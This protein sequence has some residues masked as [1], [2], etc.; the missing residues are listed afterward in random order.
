MRA[1][2]NKR[3]TVR[4]GAIVPFVALSLVAIVG[5]IAVVIDG[6]LLRDNRR[7]VQA[8]ADAAALAA[9]YDLYN[10]FQRFAGVDTGGTASRS[11]FATANANGYTNDTT[12][13]VVTVNIPPASGN[14]V[15]KPGYAE[16]IIEYKQK[17]GF[18]GMWGSGR[19][20]VK[21]RAVARGNWLSFPNGIIVLDPTD[22][23]SLNA[24]GGSQVTVTNASVI[25]NSTD[26]AGA[27]ATGGGTL[28][29]SDLY[30]GGSPGWSVS[31]GSTITGNI[32]SNSLPTPDPL[33]YLPY[34]DPSTM[35]VQDS[36]GAHISGNGNNTKTLFPGVYH[37]GISITGSP[38]VI[39]MPGIYYLDGGGFSYTG[40]GSLTGTGIMFFNAPHSN[41]DVINISGGGAVNISPPTTGIYAGITIFQERSSTNIV[42]LTGNGQMQ[43]SGTFYVAGG[44]L[45]TTGNGAGDVIG[46]QYI[47]YILNLG[48]NGGVNID[49]NPQKT[50]RKREIGL[51]E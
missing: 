7:R 4:R 15:G 38:N 33:A 37:G 50:A 3:T 17:R 51:V 46:S 28:T 22:P 5:V 6:G 32:H 47:S 23:N 43:V 9:A 20:P 2:M 10:N 41:S 36:N 44:T 13:S 29:T 35:T 19:L 49:W 48:G 24:N 8:S 16:V 34:P 14:F 45:K 26:A 11:A 31:G 21:A 30:L 25:V 18:T 39:L 42:S 1:R 27:I 40:Q 12:N